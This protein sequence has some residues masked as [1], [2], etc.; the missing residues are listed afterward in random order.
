MA[1]VWV[2]S[3]GRSVDEALKMLAA[4]VRDCS[5]ELWTAS[6]WSVQA[7]EIAGEVRDIDGRPVTDPAERDA[8]VQRWS[9]PWSVVWHALE[10]LDYD[11]GGG[12]DGWA[13]SPPFAGKP[14]WQTFTSL[15]VPWSPSEIVTYVDYCRQKVRDTLAVMTEEKAAA[16]LPPAHRYHDRPYA[17]ILTSLVGH[18]TAHAT[19][20]DS[21]SPP[22]S[23]RSDAGG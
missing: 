12:L 20:I 16:L 21:S 6:M 5:D 22:P 13:P 15:P 23:A 3:V 7:T 14:H 8:L 11:L 19:Q 2:E 4:A 1:S 18:T 9:A 10:V 17:W